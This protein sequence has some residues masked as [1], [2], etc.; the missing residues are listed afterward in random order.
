MKLEKVM[1]NSAIGQDFTQFYIG[2]IVIAAVW[3]L[4]HFEV[5]FTNLK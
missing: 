3:I 4:R 1:Q 2:K 5:W